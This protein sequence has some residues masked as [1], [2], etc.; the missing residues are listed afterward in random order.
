[1][2]FLN[3]IILIFL[4]SFL[5]V[6]V[7]YGQN[8]GFPSTNLPPIINCGDP[9]SCAIY[10]FIR[11]L[12]L[13][14]TLALVLSVIFFAW[15][16]ILYITKGGSK[17]VEKIHNRIIF[18]VIGLIV[19]FLSFASIKMIEY[20]IRTQQIFL[21]LNYVFAQI[22]EPQPP[23]SLSCGAVSVLS[24]SG[25]SVDLKTCLLFYIKKL[26]VFLYVL[27][28]ILG[29]IFFAWAG[30][31]Y[32]TKP[33]NSKNIHSKLIWAIIGVIVAILSF[34]IVKIIENFFIR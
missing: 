6:F 20:W 34:T 30:L 3:F 4:L 5:N 33:E 27:A 17:E 32:I 13:I 29:V 31:L 10:F 18:A 15:A 7:V 16:G 19:A 14:L 22:L 25:S 28:L 26:L 2:K 11:I 21:P 23:V 24:G 9:T 12:R 1:M 8:L